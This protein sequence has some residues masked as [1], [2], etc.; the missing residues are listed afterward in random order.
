MNFPC[1]LLLIFLVGDW[2]DVPPYIS[3]CPT[4]Q[5]DAHCPPSRLVHM[6]ILSTVKWLSAITQIITT[7]VHFQVL[8]IYCTHLNLN[9]S[10]FTHGMA[11]ITDYLAWHFMIFGYLHYNSAKDIYVRHFRNINSLHRDYI[12]SFQVLSNRIISYSIW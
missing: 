3:A 9:V 8:L 10:R 7:S 11:R 2:R 12:S 6:S 4:V 1:F 5:P